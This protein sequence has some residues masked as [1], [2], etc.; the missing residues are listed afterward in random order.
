MSS[1][2]YILRTLW[3]LNPEFLQVRYALS[4]RGG[5]P[6]VESFETYISKQS[7]RNKND[8]A[9]KLME[10][11]TPSI[12]A[13]SLAMNIILYLYHK[14]LVLLYLSSHASHSNYTSVFNSAFISPC[15]TSLYIQK[16][17]YF[18]TDLCLYIDFFAR[19]IKLHLTYFRLNVYFNTV[20]NVNVSQYS[21]ILPNLHNI[22]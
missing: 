3:T 7:R 15:H 11:I 17:S 6:L 13:L 19:V 22:T 18:S 14:R 20:K 21:N 10:S 1:R 12:F 16:F 2:S 4:L 8:E 9:T 5:E